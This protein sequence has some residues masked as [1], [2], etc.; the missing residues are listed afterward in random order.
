MSSLDIARPETS[1][2]VLLDQETGS[3]SSQGLTISGD[4]EGEKKGKCPNTCGTSNL[5]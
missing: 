4:T 5:G 3:E 2:L 1:E